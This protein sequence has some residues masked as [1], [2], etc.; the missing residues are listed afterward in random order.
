MVPF[1]AYCTSSSLTD[2]ISMLYIDYM[3]PF[4]VNCTSSS[5]TDGISM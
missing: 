5:L 4:Y 1:Y 3:V 2:G